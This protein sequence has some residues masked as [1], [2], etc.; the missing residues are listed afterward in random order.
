MYEHFVKPTLNEGF[1]YII[2]E[3]L[4]DLTIAKEKKDENLCNKRPSLIS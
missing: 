3:T 4:N 1:N 2:T